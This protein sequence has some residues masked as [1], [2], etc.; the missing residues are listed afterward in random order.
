MIRAVLDA[1]QFVSALLKPLSNSG[2]IL[3]LIRDDKI[4]LLTSNEIIA[5]I[6]DVLLYPKIRKRLN[7]SPEYIASFMDKIWSVAIVTKGT[8]CINAIS[9]DPSDDKYLSCAVEGKADFI[10]SGDHHLL[11]LK[12]F[13]GT[14]IVDPVTFL[15]AIL[16]DKR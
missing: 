14:K 10:V 4:R 13:K 12:T 6:T 5:E 11:D 2:T 7:R 16:K 15:S 9:D 1:N 3:T 8:L